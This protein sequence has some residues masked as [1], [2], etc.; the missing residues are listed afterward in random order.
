[1]GDDDEEWWD[2]V[3]R[4]LIVVAIV[5][6]KSSSTVNSQRLFRTVKCIGIRSAVKQRAGMRGLSLMLQ[7]VSTCEVE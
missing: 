4:A 3:V 6:V 2:D 1:M 5:M 7:D